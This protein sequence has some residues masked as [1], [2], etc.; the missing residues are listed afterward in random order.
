M[1]LEGWLDAVEATGP[2]VGAGFRYMLR[3][4]QFDQQFH[5]TFLQPFKSNKAEMT[6]L[7]HRSNIPTASGRKISTTNGRA[8]LQGLAPRPGMINGSAKGIKNVVPTVSSVISATAKPRSQWALSTSFGRNGA[9]AAPPRRSRPI[10]WGCSRGI[11]IVRR[12]ANKGATK[13]LRV[14]AVK[15]SRLLPNGASIARRVRLRPAANILLTRN[16]SNEILATP[17]AASII[18]TPPPSYDRS[19]AVRRRQRSD[20]RGSADSGDC[21]NLQ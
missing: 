18:V 6:G 7:R 20:G 13:K 4:D 17:R 1:N 8:I 11:T 3:S 5:L 21:G 15:T 9:P 19:S 12:R 14:R 16:T 10:A 2:P